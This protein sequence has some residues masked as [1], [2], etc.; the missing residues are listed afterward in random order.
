MSASSPNITCPSPQTMHLLISFDF[1]A[2]TPTNTKITP[3]FVFDFSKANLTGLSSFLMD[4]DFS[5]C[6]QSRNVELVWS[7]IKHSILT[8]MHKFTPKVTLRSHQRPKWFTPGIQHHLNFT[9]VRTLRRRHNAHPIP[10]TLQ[11]LQH[12]HRTHPAREND[13]GKACLRI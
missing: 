8:A 7:V 10:L 9:R 2:W 1:H 6:L 4:T 5:C 3:H 11:K 12:M 13:C